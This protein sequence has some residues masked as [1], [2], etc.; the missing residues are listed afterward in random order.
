MITAILPLLLA[1]PVTAIPVPAAAEV[2][3]VNDRIQL[4]QVESKLREMRCA[5]LMLAGATLADPA[6]RRHRQQ[7]PAT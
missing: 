3:G 4:A 6:K 2:L 1:F 7:H 5:D